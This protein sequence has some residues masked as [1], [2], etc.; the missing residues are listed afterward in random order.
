MFLKSLGCISA[1]SV[2]SS[3]ELSLSS[4][5]TLSTWDELLWGL[6][7]ASLADRNYDS[8]MRFESSLWSGSICSFFGPLLKMF[9][10]S[11]AFLVMM[12]A[13]IPMAAISLVFSSS[14]LI[15]IALSSFYKSGLLLPL[16]L[17]GLLAC[18]RWCESSDL[19][20]LSGFLVCLVWMGVSCRTQLST[21]LMWEEL[22]YLPIQGGDFW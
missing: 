19:S 3:F 12:G 17:S 7:Y 16:S 14:F 21:I 6:F 11:L 15:F 9:R 2:S 22:R 20:S 5:G 8:S 10:L 13:L 4:L 18:L 1:R